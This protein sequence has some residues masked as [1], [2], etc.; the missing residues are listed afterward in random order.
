MDVEDRDGRARLLAHANR[1]GGLHELER[2]NPALA[3]SASS[4]VEQTL[5]APRIA[6]AQ[7]RRDRL[8]NRLEHRR[9]AEHREA[10]S[11]VRRD[12]V[13]CR[14]IAPSPEPDH[15]TKRARPD[16]E[17]GDGVVR[18]LE[19]SQPFEHRV[20]RRGVPERSPADADR[21]DARSP[22][23]REQL[24]HRAVAANHDADPLP[25]VPRREAAH[26]FPN[27]LQSRR[28]NHAA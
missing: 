4:L 8:A 18:M 13:A 1:F 26:Q 23:R 9:V 16:V 21:L 12:P 17:R 19:E 22:Q 15:R 24:G 14:P 6:F 11:P 7:M 27:R 28:R 25:G 3:I 5:P 20:D 2:A 10:L